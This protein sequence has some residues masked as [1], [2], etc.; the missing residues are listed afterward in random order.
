MDNINAATVGIA[1]FHDRLSRMG[2]WAVVVRVRGQ[3]VLLFGQLK[4]IGVGGCERHALQEAARALRRLSVPVVAL[5]TTHSVK[6]A[7]TGT[8]SFGKSPDPWASGREWWK[9][10]RLEAGLRVARRQGDA[11]SDAL[12]RAEVSALTGAEKTRFTPEEAD[13]AGNTAFR[14]EQARERS[15]RRVKKREQDRA[16]FERGVDAYAEASQGTCRPP[17]TVESPNS[18]ANVLDE[19]LETLS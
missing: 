19:L 5:E 16:S 10:V 14:D 6:Q 17:A 12:R 8:R 1:G 7:L 13:A 15:E 9:G 11:F 18:G 3:E 2:G 4:R